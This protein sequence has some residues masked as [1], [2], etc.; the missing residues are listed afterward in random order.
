MVPTLFSHGATHGKPHGEGI[1]LWNVKSIVKAH[2][3]D[4][5]YSRDGQESV[6][7]ISL[8]SILMKPMTVVP[9]DGRFEED[10]GDALVIKDSTV[11][12]ITKQKEILIDIRDPS[13]SDT[14]ISALSDLDLVINTKPSVAKNPELI[15]TEDISQCKHLV[16]KGVKVLVDA[17][18]KSIES[19]IR[20]IRVTLTGTM[21]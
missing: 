19:A 7:T 6:F 15:Y 13:R 3:G 10:R 14:I 18:S 9:N 20:Q 4:V 16:K 11:K 12:P 5:S 2:G 17:P 8:P 1:G 21:P